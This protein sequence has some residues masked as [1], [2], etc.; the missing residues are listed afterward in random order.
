MNLFLCG[1]GHLSGDDVCMEKCLPVCR[2]IKGFE[3]D[4]FV[5][6]PRCEAR[7]RRCVSAVF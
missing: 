1:K 4:N 3:N 7:T 5:T 6:R 2:R